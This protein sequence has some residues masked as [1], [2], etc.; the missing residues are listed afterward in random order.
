ME[1]AKSSKSSP[2]A[3]LFAATVGFLAGCAVMYFVR[4]H[5]TAFAKTPA[6]TPLDTTAQIQTTLSPTPTLSPTLT[7]APASTTTAQPQP[8]NAANPPEPRAA[9]PAAL[10]GAGARQ[11][12]NEIK[13]A[14]IASVNVRFFATNDGK[15]SRQFTDFFELSPAE[16]G[17]LSDLIQATKAEM[18]DAAKTQAS[19]SQTGTDGIIIKIP[20]VAAGPDVYDRVMDGFHAVLGDDRFNDMMLYNG[21]RL[22]GG[23]FENLFNQFGGEKRTITIGKSNDGRYNVNIET[24]TS[25]GATHSQSATLKRDEIG[26]WKPGLEDFIPAN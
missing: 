2:R 20:P 21:D 16:A 7:L 19:V 6:P 24:E 1:A 15:F 3:P 17:T 5:E 23:Q 4:S 10:R 25:P 12:L 22:G 18:W 11:A 26:K 9:E 14:S 8:G 13:R